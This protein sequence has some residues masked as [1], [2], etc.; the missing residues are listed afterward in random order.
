T[1]RAVTTAGG[2]CLY[3]IPFAGFFDANQAANL[4][5]APGVVGVGAVGGGGRGASVAVGGVGVGGGGA[6][7][8]A[9]DDQASIDGRTR[10][11]TGGNAAVLG[12]GHIQVGDA[13]VSAA[14]AARTG[15]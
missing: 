7:T 6:G 1:C 8:C 3:G 5:A 9:P 12:S 11:A 15:T 14:V 2:E 10:N 13:G 4:A